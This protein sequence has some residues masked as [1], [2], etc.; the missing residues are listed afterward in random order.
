M[1]FD[2]NEHESTFPVSVD[3]TLARM[4]PIATD[5]RGRQTVDPGTWHIWEMMLLADCSDQ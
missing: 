1:T 2:V 5:I 4:K 3:R